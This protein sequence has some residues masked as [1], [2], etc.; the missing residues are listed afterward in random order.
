MKSI[1]GW[2]LGCFLS[3]VAV[4][5]A[6]PPKE[7]LT[8]AERSDYTATATCAE[9]RALCDALAAS[10][11]RIT[12]ATL[13]YSYRGIELP[14]LIVADP[15]VKTPEEARKS[16]KLVIFAFGN[17]HAGEVCGKEA[18]PMLARDVGLAEGHPLLKDLILLLAPLYNADG[19]DDMSPDHR[20][21]QVGP[22]K[23]MGVRTNGQGFDLNRDYVKLEAPETQAQLRLLNTWDPAIII[24]THTTNGSRHQYT[25]TYDGPRNEA[26]NLKILE[27]VRDRMLPDV[28]VVLEKETGYKSFFYG[29]F[30]AEHTEWSTG[31]WYPATPRYGT[32]YIGLRNR[33]SILSE[34]YAYAT[35]KDRVLA[36][37]AFA[38]HCCKYAAEHASEIRALIKDADEATA[39]AGR[40]PGAEDRTPVR[41]HNAP[42]EGKVKVLG[43]GTEEV[44]GEKRETDE[45]AEYEVSHVSRYVGTQEVRRPFAYVIEGASA[46]VVENLLRH[47]FAVEEL[48]EEREL[49]VERFIPAEVHAAERA[50]Q[51]HRLTSLAGRFETVSKRFSAGSLL[52]RTA[53]PLGN[54]LVVLL[55]PES[56]DGLFTWNFFDEGLAKDK[57]A[58]IFRLLEPTPL[59]TNKIEL[60]PDQ[61]PTPRIV[62]YENVYGRGPRPQLG[63]SAEG[64]PEWLPDGEHYVVRRDGVRYKVEARSGRM[65]AL[66]GLEA[67]AEALS[68]VEGLSKEAATRLVESGRYE[69][70]EA[71]TVALFQTDHDLF[72]ARLDGSFAAR[73]T[74]DDKGEEMATLSPDGKWA[75]FIKDGDLFVVEIETRIER[76]LT[77]D[78]EGL[79][80]NGKADWVYYEEIFNRNWK[81]F[82]WSPDSK[83]IAFMRFDDTPVKTFLVIN[84][85]PV[86]QNVETLRYPKAGSENP[87]IRVG[88][89]TLPDGQVHWADFGEHR[90]EDI[91]VSDVGW[92]SDGAE[93]IFY[94]QD[95]AQR[96]LNVT[97]FPR[98]GGPTR[99]LLQ[100]KSGAWLETPGMPRYLKDGSFLFFSERTGFKHLYH[101]DADGG[102]IAPITKG[103]FEARR[104]FHV[105]EKE[106]WIIFSGMRDSSIAE[107]LYRV[108]MD[109][110]DLRRLTP[111]EGD[112]DC[113]VSPNGLLFVD[114]FQSHAEPPRT[115]LRQ[116]D[117]TRVRWVDTNPVN[118]GVNWRLSPYELFQIEMRDGYKIEAA[119]IKPPD[120]DPSKKYPVW[121]RTYA[122]P[123][124]P[125]VS[126]QW[127]G[128]RTGEQAVASMGILLFRCDPRSASGKG[129]LSAWSAYRQLGVQEMKDIEDAIH[130]LKKEPFVDG[131]R[132]GM[133]G[134]SYGGY[135]TAYAM[136]HSTL[137]C[138]GIAGAPVTDWRYYDTIYTERYMDTPQNNPEGYKAAS[139]VDAAASLHGRLLL[140]HGEID[141]NVHL[142]NTMNLAAALQRANKQFDLMIYPGF[143]HGIF[144]A[145][146]NQLTM[147]FMVR[148]LLDKELSEIAP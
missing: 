93:Q 32:S 20:P 1:Q 40:A 64:P 137:F 17:I 73:L 55:E 28:S 66:K 96:W 133:S 108:R 85:E 25:L 41:G 27:F 122:G 3:L 134:H 58:P 118:D 114:R 15:P 143:R 59:L 10:S 72:A 30:N 120:F 75:A 78:G 54:L 142:Q 106:G 56:E 145:H 79:V 146:Y 101:Y 26:G 129:A 46:D 60:D 83:A 130:W 139:V 92:T 11:P 31:E 2:V 126:D 132:I 77:T 7:L 13:G 136:T 147:E 81:A 57:P 35:Y 113:S 135:M 99:V 62:A 124:S 29:N 65:E 43:Y 49:D 45:P 14:L 97:L 80:T 34:A 50:F 68:K 103:E 51:G 88:Q 94:L 115:V 140:L 98:G 22:E 24:D 100:E 128:G 84:Q 48:R 91:V 42:Y 61:A 148:H 119:L 104:I 53:Q 138:C 102:L 44:N 12:R 8:V 110:S 95:R 127:Q 116:T 33:I 70:D 123:H 74:H 125:T 105:D 47:G 39:Q 86:Y 36:T 18:L 89:A 69:T 67:V 82:W 87:L 144:G 38:E 90:A 4:G 9:V 37:R 6:S 112:H 111:E 23:G 19:N 107:N 76:A 121:F 131:D 109:G 63:G 141:D 16:G 71:A 5:R 52:L 21:G 117:G